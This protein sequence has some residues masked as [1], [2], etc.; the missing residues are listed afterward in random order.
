M[1]TCL[2]LDLAKLVSPLFSAQIHLPRILQ[3]P[4]A[5]WPIGLSSLSKCI[6][7]ILDYQ[8]PVKAE[9][10]PKPDMREISLTKE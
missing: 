2:V 7:N 4:V 10:E 3:D 1:L 8:E 5:C 9:R 6:I